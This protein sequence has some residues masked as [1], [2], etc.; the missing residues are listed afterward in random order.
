[1]PTK[2]QDALERVAEHQN[3]DSVELS[4]ASRL[5]V[6]DF[7]RDPLAAPTLEHEP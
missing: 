3:V 2:P 7:A 5:N 4:M 1:M 6:T